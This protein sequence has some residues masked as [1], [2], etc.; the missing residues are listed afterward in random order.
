MANLILNG[1]TSGS[2][3]LSSPAVSGTTTLTLPTT[4][5]TVVTTG[6]T[7]QVIASGALPIGSVLQVVNAITS[8]NVSNS[9]ATMADTGLTATITPKFSTSKILVLV[10][11]N[12]VY[13][14]AANANNMVDLILARNGTG[15]LGANFSGATA[16]TSTALENSVTASLCYLDSPATT[17]ATTYKTQFNSRN[18]TASVSV[19]YAGVSTSFITLMEIAG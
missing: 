8:T 4:S 18:G 9:T 15:I 6:T 11:Q 7:G 19:Q 10:S 16:A 3:T 2:V 1:S 13:K 14:S 17:S 12:G 5:G